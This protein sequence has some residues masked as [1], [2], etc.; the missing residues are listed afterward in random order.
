MLSEAAQRIPEYV[1]SRAR[2]ANE[3]RFE[4][5]IRE[6]GEKEADYVSALG[7]K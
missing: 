6:E 4:N 1:V 5:K 7:N 2:E 3:G